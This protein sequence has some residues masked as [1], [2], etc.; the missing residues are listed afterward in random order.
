MTP[1]LNLKVVRYRQISEHEIQRQELLRQELLSVDPGST[2]NSFCPEANYL[3]FLCPA[4]LPSPFQNLCHMRFGQKLAKHL[5]KR[6][7][8]G[9][10]YAQMISCIGNINKPGYK[11]PRLNEEGGGL[12][13]WVAP[14]S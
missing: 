4:P 10:Q 13:W 9:K 3:A 11:S 5:L 7:E 2:A 1:F 14:T 12:N 8:D 6:F